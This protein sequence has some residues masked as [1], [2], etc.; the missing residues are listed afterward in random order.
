MQRKLAELIVEVEAAQAL[1]FDG[2]LGPRLRIGAPLIKLRAARLGITA[3]SDAI[4]IHGGNGYIE[5]W[6][7]ARLLPRRP[8]EHGVGGPGQHPV[9]RRASRHREARTPTCPSSPACAT[10]SAGAPSGDDATVELVRRRIDDVAAAIDVWRG[11]DRTTAEARLYRLAQLMVDVYAAAL[12][13]EQAGWSSASS[14]PTASS[15]SPASTCGTTSWTT[16]RCVASTRRPRSWP[17]SRTSSTAPSSRSQAAVAR[18]GVKRPPAV[19]FGLGGGQ[20]RGYWY[21]RPCGAEGR[22]TV[23]RAPG[24]APASAAGAAAGGRRRLGRV[25]AAAQRR[26]GRPAQ[27][28]RRAA[29]GRQP[30][31]GPARRRG[32]GR[33]HR[34]HQR[35]LPDRSSRRVRRRRPL[36]RAGRDGPLVGRSGVRPSTRS[37]RRWRCGGARSFGELAD[38]PFLLAEAERLT[39]L[40]RDA[41]ELRLAALLRLGTDGLVP[42]LEAAVADSPL[43]ERRTFLLM[44]ALYR[45]GRQAEALAAYRRLT[46]ALRDDLGLSPSDELRELERRILQHDPSLVGDRARSAPAGTAAPDPDAVHAALGRARSARALARAG[47]VDESMR[48]ADA[49]VT[50]APAARRGD[51]RRVPGGVGA[52]RSPWPGGPARPSPPSTRRCRSPGESGDAGVLA[53]AAHRPLRLRAGRRGRAAAA[54]LTEPLELAGAR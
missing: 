52:G 42:D 30:A 15:S 14:A 47:V 44:L 19:A 23:R 41:V 28:R 21:P 10:P 46:V 34:P 36:R 39:S 31:A 49:A 25:V 32:R 9:P 53:T 37:R 54:L 43:R 7:V 11:L 24:R 20:H 6:P 17:G 5:Q 8:G 48:I 22:R 4:E 51:A 33:R 16:V 26:L 50:A 12:L 13:L 3:A 45:D 40:R 18:L 1:V 38:E 35:R 29:G 2:Y 27:V